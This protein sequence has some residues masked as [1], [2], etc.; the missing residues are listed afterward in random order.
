[1]KHKIL[2]TFTYLYIINKSRIALKYKPVILFSNF[3]RSTTPNFNLIKIID[4]YT[5]KNVKYF[6][7]K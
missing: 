4:I 3:A 7:Y 2:L 5:E 6:G 1:M